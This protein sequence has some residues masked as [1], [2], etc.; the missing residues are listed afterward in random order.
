M[1]EIIEEITPILSVNSMNLVKKLPQHSLY[2]KNTDSF[3]DE[4]WLL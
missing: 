2:H 1:Y 4:Y 3:I